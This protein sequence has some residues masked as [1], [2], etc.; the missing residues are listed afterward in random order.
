MLIYFLHA[1]S[2][3]WIQIQLFASLMFKNFQ[4]PVNISNP[5]YFLL[6]RHIIKFSNQFY[7]KWWMMQCVHKNISNMRKKSVNKK[8][9]PM[10]SAVIERNM[11]IHG[12][13]APGSQMTM[14]GKTIYQIVSKRKINFGC[15]VWL[16]EKQ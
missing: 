9:I 14:G 3:S 16:L 1:T 8:F 12:K 7:F 13:K 10:H 5:P 6:T 11:Q 4:R 15:I 2:K